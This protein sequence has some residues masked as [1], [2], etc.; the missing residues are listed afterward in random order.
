MFPRACEWNDVFARLCELNVS[1]F[2]GASKA[3]ASNNAGAE[4]PALEKAQTMLAS[5]G[6]VKVDTFLV[7]STATASNSKGAETPIV[8]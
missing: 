4:T 7:A 8:A 2:F 6:E 3:T 1:I 5:S